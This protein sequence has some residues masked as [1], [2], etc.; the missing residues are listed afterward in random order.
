MKS[1]NENKNIDYKITRIEVC[2]KSTGTSGE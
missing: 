1:L 2:Y